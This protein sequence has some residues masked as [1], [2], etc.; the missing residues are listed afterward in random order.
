M[1]AYKAVFPTGPVVEGKIDKV[2]SELHK[3]AKEIGHHPGYLAPENEF[4]HFGILPNSTR[5]ETC[6][7]GTSLL[8]PNYRSC[9][10]RNVFKISVTISDNFCWIWKC[11]TT[12]ELQPETR[13]SEYAKSLGKSLLTTFPKN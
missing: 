2:M 10:K 1:E 4:N 3:L 5:Q 12:K 6:K 7:A 9:R 13:R 11:I 8:F